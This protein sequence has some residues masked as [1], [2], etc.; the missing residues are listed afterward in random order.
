MVLGFGV[1]QGMCFLGFRF[2]GTCMVIETPFLFV[3]LL[4]RL[5]MIMMMTMMITF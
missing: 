3:L 5:V 4:R 2:F 1:F